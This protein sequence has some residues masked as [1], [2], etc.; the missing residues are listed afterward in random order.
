VE[1]FART[2]L[3]VADLAVVLVH[4]RISAVGPPAEV[5]ADLTSAYLGHAA[6]PAELT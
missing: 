1:Q 5:A 3:G 6:Q 2:V 4:G